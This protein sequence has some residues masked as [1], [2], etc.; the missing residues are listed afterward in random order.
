[1]MADEALARDIGE[2]WDHVL[3]DEYQDTNVLQAEILQRLRPSGEGMTVVGDDAQA[4]YSFRAASVENIRGF[5]SSFQN[6]RT[7]PL[8]EN[9]RSTQPVLD[10]ANALIGKSLH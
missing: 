2:N 6:T 4:I 5:A 9:Y 3:V 7:I 10:A 8:E 1:M